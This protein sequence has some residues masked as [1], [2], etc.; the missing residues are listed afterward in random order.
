[1]RNYKK[2]HGVL[3]GPQLGK[4]RCL[5]RLG[6]LRVNDEFVEKNT[7]FIERE[8]II[9]KMRYKRKC[10]VANKEIITLSRQSWAKRN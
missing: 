6:I 4:Q 5:P 2:N 10:A 1:M 7:R 3:R 8:Y 9:D